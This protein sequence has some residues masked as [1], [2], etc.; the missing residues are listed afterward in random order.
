MMPEGAVEASQRLRD[1][2]G[3]LLFYAKRSQRYHDHRR[4]FFES[5]T[6]WGQFIGLVAG[7]AGFAAYFG[8][9][10]KS[11]I[12]AFTSAAGAVASAL[13][14]SF[15][16]SKMAELHSR[17][18][19][20]CIVFEQQLWKVRNPTEK[21]YQTFQQDR[22]E[23]EK[24]EPRV[25]HA[26]LRMCRNEVIRCE[27]TKGAIRDLSRWQNIWKDV[28]RFKNLLKQIPAN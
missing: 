3:R 20:K 26:V 17:L 8:V 5:V 23:I 2:R 18:L 21:D 1:E 13:L 12:L 25:Y 22:L 6:Q 11:E 28:W 24:L 9:E 15:K 7:S 4:G 16:A 14:I 10:E 27:G 19:E